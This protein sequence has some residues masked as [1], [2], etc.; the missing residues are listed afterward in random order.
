MAEAERVL[1]A[2]EAAFI[3]ACR[4]ARLATIGRT[5]LPHLVPVCFVRIGDD[6]YVAV[7]EK[8][9][10][11]G[12]LARVRNLRRD[13]RAT[14]LFDHYADDWRQLAWVRAECSA[15]VV[16]RGG[17]APDVLARLRERYPQYREM[18]LEVLPLLRFTVERSVSWRWSAG[19]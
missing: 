6:L 17:E 5:G 2:S 10:R 7:D 16:E 19:T 15:T 9:K 13:P 3:D 12:E 8:P 11:A 1:A 18:A 14:L 4:V